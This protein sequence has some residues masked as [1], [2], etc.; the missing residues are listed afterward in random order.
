LT[1]GSRAIVD[2]GVYCSRAFED[3]DGAWFG[4]RAE[5]PEASLVINRRVS[6]RLPTSQ[7]KST[8]DE[9]IGD[10][11]PTQTHPLREAPFPV[12]MQN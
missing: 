1:A 2:Q 10:F 9:R 8:L 12:L 11:A 3:S 4:M 5:L 6:K 7:A